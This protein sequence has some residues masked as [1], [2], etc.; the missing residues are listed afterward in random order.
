MNQ[1]KLVAKGGLLSLTGDAVNYSLG[2]VF[3]LIATHFLGPAYLGIYYFAIS[4]AGLLGE[5]AE[6]GIG[7]GLMY[8][9]PKFEVEKGP[10][11]SLPLLNFALWFTMRNALFLAGLLFICAHP[12]AA[13][14]GKADYAWLLQLAALCIPCGAF[15]PILYKYCV[16]RFKIVEGILYGDILRPILRVGILLLL[17]FLGIKSLTLIGCEILVGALLI[18]I[19]LYLINKNWGLSFLT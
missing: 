11:G 15:W 6:C 12:L 19:G 13:F 2:Y 4:I 16:A 5:F 18:I 14:F 1:L 3:L 10:D 7:Q 17:I 9:G 8:F